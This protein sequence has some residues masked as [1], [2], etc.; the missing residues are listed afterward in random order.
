MSAPLIAFP[1]LIGFWVFVAWRV[2]VERGRVLRS[3]LEQLAISIDWIT[4][5]IGEAF[6]PAIRHAATAL[7]AFTRAWDEMLAAM[8]DE[9][10]RAFLALLDSEGGP[11]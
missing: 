10:R 1:L 4:R 8:G 2:R 11:A 7:A 5:T 3:P 9:E 6:V